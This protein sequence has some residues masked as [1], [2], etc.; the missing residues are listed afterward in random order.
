MGKGQRLGFGVGALVLL[1][2]LGLSTVAAENE[3]TETQIFLRGAKLWGAYCGLCHNARSGSEFNRL[4]WDTL[5]LHMRV[6]ANLPAE[7]AEAIRVFL[8]SSH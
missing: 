8:R 4:E 1:L 2:A 7:D 6:R 5:L 3:P